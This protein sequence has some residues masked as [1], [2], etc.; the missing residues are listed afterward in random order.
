MWF[1]G[2]CI[3]GQF[4]SKQQAALSPVMNNV[5]HKGQTASLAPSEGKEVPTVTYKAS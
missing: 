2:S 4:L 1:K 3:L 5:K